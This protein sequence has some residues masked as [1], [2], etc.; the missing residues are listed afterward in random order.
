EQLGGDGL[1][2][3]AARRHPARRRE[4]VEGDDG[5]DT[6]LQAR[7]AHATVVVEMGAREVAVLRLDAAPL[8]REAVGVEAQAREQRHVLAVAMVVI[9]GVG[10]GLRAWRA[11]GVLPRPPVVVPVAPLDLMRRGRGAPDEPLRKAHGV[12][13]TLP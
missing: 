7:R 8:Q 10:T 13:T 5:R 2:P 6:V 11:G 9:A 1:G 3:A 12:T 4:V